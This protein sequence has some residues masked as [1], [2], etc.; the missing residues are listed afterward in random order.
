MPANPPNVPSLASSADEDDNTF[1][2]VNP[3]L[4][5]AFSASTD[6]RLAPVNT[7]KIPAGIFAASLAASLAAS[8]FGSAIFISL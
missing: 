2:K 7:L 8:V 1:P 5:T 3:P 6:L 4:A